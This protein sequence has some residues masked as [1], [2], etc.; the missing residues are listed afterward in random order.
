[1]VLLLLA[2]TGVCVVEFYIVHILYA[3]D[4]WLLRVPGVARFVRGARAHGIRARGR[5]EPAGALVTMR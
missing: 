1:M 3:D 4:H 2:P 5:L